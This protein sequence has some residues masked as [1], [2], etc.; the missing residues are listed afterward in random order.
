MYIFY[1]YILPYFFGYKTEFFLSKSITRWIE[2][3]GINLEE[4][5]QYETRLKR[6]Y[7][8][9]IFGY[10]MHRENHV[11]ELDEYGISVMTKK[12]DFF[13]IFKYSRTSVARTSLEP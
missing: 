9:Y 12:T 2:L 13:L 4:K 11:L 1:K 7:K 3:F 8:M 5:T 10:F 6:I